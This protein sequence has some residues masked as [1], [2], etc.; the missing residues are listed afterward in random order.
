MAI[1][2]SFNFF[3]MGTL[4]LNPT[5]EEK[6]IQVA[7]ETGFRGPLRLNIFLNLALNA[8]SASHILQFS[9]RGALLNPK[10]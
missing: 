10:F 5:H 3:V 4:T 1:I 8:K 7:G 6:S 2:K 9:V